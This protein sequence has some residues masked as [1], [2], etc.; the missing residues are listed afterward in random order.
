[1]FSVS[2]ASKELSNAASPLE[3]TLVRGSVDSKASYVRFF[4]SIAGADSKR[5][6]E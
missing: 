1:M 4:R 3:S 2:V 5:G 6:G